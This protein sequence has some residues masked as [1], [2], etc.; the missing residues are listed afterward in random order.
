MRLPAPQQPLVIDHSGRVHAASGLFQYSQHST[1]QTQSML[2]CSGRSS[3]ACSL[4]VTE[5]DV[6]ST[7]RRSGQCG[8]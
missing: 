4:R 8:L 5:S 3:A 2:V 7:A 1:L 6:P